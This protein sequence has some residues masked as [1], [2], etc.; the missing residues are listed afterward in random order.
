MNT[1]HHNFLGQSRIDY[2]LLTLKSTALKRLGLEWLKI[3]VVVACVPWKCTKQKWPAH[4]CA[5]CIIISIAMKTETVVTGDSTLHLF[6][7][8]HWVSD[9]ASAPSKAAVTLGPNNQNRAT[10]VTVTW[11]CLEKYLDKGSSAAS[12]QEYL[13]SCSWV[14]YCQEGIWI[15]NNSYSVHNFGHSNTRGFRKPKKCLFVRW[16]NQCY[17]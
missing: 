15:L 3:S 17:Y 9:A 16:K 5:W 1:T 6:P 11:G 10:C 2:F 8:P 4:S 14:L 12:F 7:F 13:C